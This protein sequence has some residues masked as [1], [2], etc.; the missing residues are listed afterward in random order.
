MI[1]SRYLPEGGDLLRPQPETLV[2]DEQALAYCELMEL[3]PRAETVRDLRMALPEDL[4]TRAGR[5]NPWPLHSDAE[6]RQPTSERF[7]RAFG[8]AE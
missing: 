6:R 1:G 3:E 5:K 4:G 8:F 7:N 2:T